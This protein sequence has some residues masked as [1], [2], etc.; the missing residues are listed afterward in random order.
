VGGCGVLGRSVCAPHVSREAHWG[1]TGRHR[2]HVPVSL[3]QWLHFCPPQI[4]LPLCD[5]ARTCCD[6]GA[7]AQALHVGW[8]RKCHAHVMCSAAREDY[9]AKHRTIPR[10]MTA[11]RDANERHDDS[12]Q[13]Q[14]THRWSISF[15]KKCLHFT[16]CAAT[17]SGLK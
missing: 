15:C 12:D 6:L 16:G 1:P 10:S 8:H 2:P 7:G 11:V 17:P 4:G 5:P 13:C 9:A 3:A 14:P